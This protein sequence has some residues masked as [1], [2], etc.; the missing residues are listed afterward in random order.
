MFESLYLHHF[1]FLYKY[2]RLY[3]AFAFE[4]CSKKR[5]NTIKN[6]DKHT[7]KHTT[8]QGNNLIASWS[9]S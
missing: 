9:W 6:K 4:F 2:F 8:I 3:L 5:E 1:L 7:T